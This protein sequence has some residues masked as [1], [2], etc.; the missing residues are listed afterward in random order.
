MLAK[1]KF[2]WLF[3]LGALVW[4]F[5]FYLAL[6]T[7]VI[8]LLFDPPKLVRYIIQLNSFEGVQPSIH[9]IGVTVAGDSLLILFIASGAYCLRVCLRAR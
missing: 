6:A 4:V 9:N 7:G 8:S 2:G 3:W 1:S 5:L